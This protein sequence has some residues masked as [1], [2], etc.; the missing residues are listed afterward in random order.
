MFIKDK[1]RNCGINL[2]MPFRWWLR[3]KL[4]KYRNIKPICIGCK[5][6]G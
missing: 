1:C 2:N 3:W 5:D 4:S 6:N